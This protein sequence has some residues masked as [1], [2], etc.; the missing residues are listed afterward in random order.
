M[1]NPAIIRNKLYMANVYLRDIEE[2]KAGDVNR[3]G[4]MVDG[5]GYGLG[6]EP[7]WKEKIADI[8]TCSETSAMYPTE[9]AAIL[10]RSAKLG[11]TPKAM[12]ATSQKAETLNEY[13]NARELSLKAQSAWAKLYHSGRRITWD[14]A[15]KTFRFWQCPW[16]NRK[17]I[18]HYGEFGRFDCTEYKPTQDELEVVEEYGDIWLSGFFPKTA[19]DALSSWFYHPLNADYE[20]PV[21]HNMGLERGIVIY[22]VPFDGGAWPMISNAKAANVERAEV[23]EAPKI[24]RKFLEDK[25]ARELV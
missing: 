25:S 18:Q 12:A 11:I 10:D 1:L 15:K 8:L 9:Y 3:F 22:T 16:P 5:R 17:R 24:L 4:R 7:G 20:V 23:R 21:L 14:N 2:L 6:S 13:Q 19:P